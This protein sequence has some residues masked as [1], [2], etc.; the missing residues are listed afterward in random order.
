MLST[1]QLKYFKTLFDNFEKY[2]EVREI[3]GNSVKQHFMT[4]NELLDYEPPADKNVYVGMFERGRK[5]GGKV[6]TTKTHVLYL[7]FD[8]TD[9]D[10]IIFQIDMHHIPQPSMIVNSGHGFHVYWKLSEPAGHEI[11]PVLKAVQVKLN[12]DPQAVD[13]ARVLRVP[14]TMNVKGEPVRAKLISHNQNSYPLQT[15]ED[16]LNVRAA[17]PVSHA[18]SI[19]ELAEIRF[20][21]LNNMAAGVRK[22]ERNFATARIVQTLRRL[23]YTKQETID[24]VMQWNRLNTPSK[25]TKEIKHDINVFWYE[26]T[27]KDRY[28]YDGKTFTDDRLQAL[29]ECFTDD[30]T[31]YFN[32]DEID[33]HNYDN[34]LLK[35]QNFKRTSGLT[36]AVLSIIKLSESKG[37]R[38]EHIA[39]LCKRHEKDVNLRKSLKELERLKYINIILKGQINY[40]VFSEKANYKR[41]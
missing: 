16:V 5:Q 23:N 27:D 34:E 25:N 30:S 26:F 21:G 8:D 9:L 3:K 32:G 7:D 37:I 40:Y 38:R 31:T 24:I 29:N 22:G 17:D 13:V 2:V 18:S 1:N 20:N 14:D 6:A 28:R 15:F 36:F 4:Y 11:E 41:G 33:T 39:D 35:P 12:A 10:T 19:P